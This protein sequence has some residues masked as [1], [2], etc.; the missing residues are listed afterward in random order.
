[1]TAAGHYWDWLAQHGWGAVVFAAFAAVLAFGVVVSLLTAARGLLVWAR[2]PRQQAEE[3][4]T[5][6]VTRLPAETWA[7]EEQ[8]KALEDRLARIEKAL[9]ARIESLRSEISEDRKKTDALVESIRQA[10]RTILLLVNFGVLQT[11]VASLGDLIAS[12]P[13]IL[14]DSELS[15]ETREKHADYIGKVRS[16][17]AGTFRGQNVENVLQMAEWEAERA[18]EATPIERRNPADPIRYRRWA[19]ANQQAAS[20][21]NFL[22]ASQ[23][24]VQRKIVWERSNFAD[25]FTRRNSS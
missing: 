6:N 13:L 16:Q 19:I 22:I 4:K 9:A 23:T 18:I 7:D 21:V 17:L 25:E 24:E 5:S 2:H 8:L 20:L 11:V 14:P 12:A 3:S 1:L 15:E 10:D